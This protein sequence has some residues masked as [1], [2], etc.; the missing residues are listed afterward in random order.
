MTLSLGRISTILE[1]N[2]NF[3]PQGALSLANALRDP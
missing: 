1:K 3:G 2:K